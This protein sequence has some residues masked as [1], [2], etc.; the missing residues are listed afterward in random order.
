MNGGQLNP[1]H[2]MLGEYPHGAARAEHL[3]QEDGVPVKDPLDTS[4]ERGGMVK[5]SHN[6]LALAAPPAGR[7]E[8]RIRDPLR[9]V[10]NQA[11]AR[12]QPRAAGRATGCKE[13][14]ERWLRVGPRC[15]ADRGGGGSGTTFVP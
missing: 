2:L 12:D 15:R 13:R 5:G 4:G 1:F 7:L 14:S 6:Q 8:Q 10:A 3:L 9:V 11:R